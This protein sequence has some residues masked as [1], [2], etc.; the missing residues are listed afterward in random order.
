MKS[1]KNLT[2]EANTTEKALRVAAYIRVST[3]DQAESGLGLEAQRTQCTAMATVK[4]WNAPM[5]YEDA[6]ISGTK[7]ET[8]RP[9]L[10]QLLADVR[11]GLID[12]L[13]IAS[14]DRL[15]R[16]VILTLQIARELKKNG[17]DLVSCKESL[18]T[19]TAQGQFVLGLF[20]LL[21]EWERSR[22]S[23]RTIAALRERRK[24]DGE[25]GGRMP[26]GYRR[27]DCGISIIP[28]EAEIVRKIFAMHK[29]GISLRKIGEST[30]KRHTSIVEILRNKD[31]YRGG[32]RHGSSTCWPT[33]L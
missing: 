33:I 13:I 8:E 5:F 26:F 7:D 15:G 3:D 23:E 22:I 4:G 24:R 21:A 1:K 2:I 6:G 32:Y 29:R 20:A 9:G 18:D 25:T 17:V 30:G 10:A 14:L 28:E 19:G 31:A 27:T 16:D 12:T 11:D